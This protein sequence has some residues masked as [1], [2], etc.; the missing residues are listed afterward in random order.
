MSLNNEACFVHDGRMNV[1][2]NIQQIKT[3]EQVSQFLSSTADASI[4]PPSK[5]EGYRWIEHTLKQTI[6]LWRKVSMAQR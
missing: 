4:T 6:M 3:P 1:I 5:D 2:V